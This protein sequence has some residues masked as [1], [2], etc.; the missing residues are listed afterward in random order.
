MKFGHP[1]ATGETSFKRSK[2]PKEEEYINNLWLAI[3]ELYTDLYVNNADH[4]EIRK[5]ILQEVKW[6]MDKMEEDIED[7]DSEL[8]QD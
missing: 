7:P 5:Y 4:K 8:Y 6:N 2:N 1:G 3:Q